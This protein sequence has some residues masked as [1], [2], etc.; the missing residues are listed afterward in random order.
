MTKDANGERHDD[1]STCLGRIIVRVRG[2]AGSVFCSCCLHMVTEP[3]GV[4]TFGGLCAI[5]NGAPVGLLILLATVM[6]LRNA[7]AYRTGW[8]ATRMGPDVADHRCSRLTCCGR[9]RTGCSP[10]NSR[11]G[12]CWEAFVAVRRQIRGAKTLYRCATIG[13]SATGSTIWGFGDAGD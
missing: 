1:D 5:P 2:L 7:C 8:V 9:G 12:P 10:E 4:G 11:S 13:P 6:V 3:D